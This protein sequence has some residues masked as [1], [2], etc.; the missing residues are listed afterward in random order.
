[1]KTLKTICFWAFNGLLMCG[2]ILFSFYF[3]MK[4]GHFSWSARSA[5]YAG[6]NL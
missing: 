6:D 3:F 5:V 1:M 2:L 4:G